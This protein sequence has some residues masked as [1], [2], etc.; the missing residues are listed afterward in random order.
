VGGK[1]VSAAEYE[2]CAASKSPLLKASVPA[3]RWLLDV[4]S[5]EGEMAGTFRGG[6][7]GRGAWGTGVEALAATGRGAGV[8]LVE[9]GCEGGWTGAGLNKSTSGSG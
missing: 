3:R 5:A 4:E 2:L 8:A 1:G 9:V 7:F 6:A